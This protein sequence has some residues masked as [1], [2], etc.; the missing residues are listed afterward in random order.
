LSANVEASLFA[1]WVSFYR[2]AGP[3]F[4][5]PANGPAHLKTKRTRFIYFRISIFHFHFTAARLGEKKPMGKSRAGP[6]AGWR[7]KNYGNRVHDDG[8]S[9]NVAMRAARNHQADIRMARERNRIRGFFRA[10]LTLQL[11]VHEFFAIFRGRPRPIWWHTRRLARFHPSNTRSAR[12]PW[13]LSARS[14]R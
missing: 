9:G 8:R 14:F 11:E 4:K 7:V 1:P 3:D 12:A 2:E 6:Q 10:D 13:Q 5:K